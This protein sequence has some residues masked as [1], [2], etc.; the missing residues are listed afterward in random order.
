MDDLET[1]VPGFHA[2]CHSP[3]ASAER[4]SLVESAG[5]FL[6]LAGRREAEAATDKTIKT[7]RRRFI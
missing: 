7:A 3:Q 6:D 2:S 1:A 4:L 5:G